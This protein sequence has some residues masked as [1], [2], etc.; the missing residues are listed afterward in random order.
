[1]SHVIRVTDEDS[2]DPFDWAYGVPP[3][4]YVWKPEVERMYTEAKRA[5][6]ELYEE[7]FGAGE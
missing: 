5:I 4:H 3:G 2:L 6:D 1:M 7:M